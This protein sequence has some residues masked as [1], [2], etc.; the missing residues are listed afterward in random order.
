MLFNSTEF[1]I[2]FPI[3]VFVYFMT[4]YRLRWVI[5]LVASYYFYMAWKASYIILIVISTLIDY[6]SSHMMSRYSEKK[7]RRPFLYLSIFTNLGLLFTFKY[8]NFFNESLA[9]TFNFLNLS[10][11]IPSLEVLLPVGISFYTFQTMSYSIDVYQGKIKPEKHLGIF[12]VF[13]AFFPQLVAGPIERAGNLLGQF[14]KSFDFN[15]VRVTDG[16]KLMAWGMFKKVVIADN[17]AIMVN[18]V[19]NNPLEYEGIS[20]VIATIFFA[21][22]I[23]CDFSGY[24]DI[25]IGAAQVMGFKLMLNFNR[26][27]YAKSISEFWKRWHISLSTWFRDYTYIP[28]GGNRVVKWR[29]Y[30]NLFITFLVSGLWHGANWTFVIWGAVHGLYLILAVVSKEKWSAFY[31]K[32]N[33]NPSGSLISGLQVLT[34]FSLVCF[35]WIFFRANNLSDALYIIQHSFSSISNLWKMSAS[36]INHVLFLDG[37]FNIFMISV[38]AILIMEIIHFMQRKGS[39]RLLLTRRPVWLRW[40][41]Y[42]FLIFSILLFGQFESQDFIYFQF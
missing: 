13:V 6:F 26:P 41:A 18:N 32:F 33:I 24:S 28:L 11:S 31:Q 19:Y 16:L 3:V 17:L 25:A 10:Y 12:A 23:Y 36:D 1:L 21:F 8:F 5:L 4:P 35:A 30:Y 34:T 22:Q 39:I 15:Y 7:Q 2:F 29:W 40:L 38:F 42:Y 37:G 14:R 27:Y 9:N 20:L